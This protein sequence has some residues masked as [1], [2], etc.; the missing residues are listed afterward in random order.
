MAADSEPP[1]YS[2]DITAGS[3][4][5]TESRVIADLLC[6]GIG[7]SG[8]ED[9]IVHQNVLRAS[10]PSTAIRV[11]RLVRRRLEP[12]GPELW[13]LVRDGNGTVALHATLAAAIHH[14]RLLGDFL[15]LVVRE[16]CRMFAKTLSKRLWDDY[17]VGCR[18]R[19][20]SVSEW[21]HSTCVKCGTVVYHILAQAGFI[22]DCRR[23]QLQ[24]VHIASYVVDYLQAHGHRYVLRC[25]QVMP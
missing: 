15:D 23:L 12:M 13:R 5:L 17:L 20:P 25:M 24:T 2:A 14:S 18:G 4:K 1:R 22:N 8:W 10:R 16:Q 3:L 6:R 21:S 9:A 7:Q 11:A 19:D